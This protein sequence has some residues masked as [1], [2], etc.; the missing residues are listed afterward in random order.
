MI[1]FASRLPA[2]FKLNGLNEKFI[3]KKAAAGSIPPELINRPKQ[4]YRA[5]ISKCFLGE[6]KLDYVEALLSGDALKKAGYFN[7]N[8]VAGLIAKGRRQNGELKTE[9]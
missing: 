9:R 5:P 1:E 7:P 6:E 4:P 2:R 8:K 3:L